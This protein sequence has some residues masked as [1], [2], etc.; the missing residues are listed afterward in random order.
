MPD[1]PKPIKEDTVIEYVCDC[2]KASYEVDWDRFCHDVGFTRKAAIEVRAAVE[3]AGSKELLRPIKDQAPE[4]VCIKN[5]M[6]STFLILDFYSTSLAQ[7]GF[8]S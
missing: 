1:R 7:L 8:S 2:I 4:H 3:K 6:T 5:L